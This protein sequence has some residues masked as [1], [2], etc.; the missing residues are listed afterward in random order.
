MIQI[1]HAQ[2]E[3]ELDKSMIEYYEYYDK[4]GISDKE[5]FL[6]GWPALDTNGKGEAW[7]NVHSFYH[8]VEKT[9]KLGDY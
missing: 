4:I 1:Q 6:R 9:K 5:A 2:C 7:C 3:E 8:D